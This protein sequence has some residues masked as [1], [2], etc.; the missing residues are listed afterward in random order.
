M[1]VKTTLVNELYLSAR[2][3]TAWPQLWNATSAIGTST[4][5]A[6]S[7]DDLG[8]TLSMTAAAM[9]R[10]IWS[11]NDAQRTQ[12]RLGEKYR[13]KRLKQN[14]PMQKEMREVPDLIHRLDS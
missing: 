13:W 8:T 5:Q 6:S 2:L 11:R 1:L 9:M 3:V 10:D 14:D 4:F 12:R 7:S